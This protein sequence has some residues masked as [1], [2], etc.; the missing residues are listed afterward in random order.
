[1][2]ES[3]KGSLYPIKSLFLK[4]L[5]KV[6]VHCSRFRDIFP[7]HLLCECE[8]GAFVPN[9]SDIYIKGALKKTIGS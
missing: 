3:G 8:K 6:D 5:F 9:C 1:M 2:D 7:K 4:P